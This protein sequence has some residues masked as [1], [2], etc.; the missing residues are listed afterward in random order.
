MPLIGSYSI[1]PTFTE[2]Y[3]S[4]DDLLTQLPDN[5]SNSIVAQD[6]RDAVY[7][8]WKNIEDVSIIASASAT[9]SVQYIRTTPSTAPT[10]GGV[11]TGSTFSG[12]I[13]ETLDRIFYPYIAPASSFTSLSNREFGSPTSV[14]LNWS[15]TKNSNTITT[16]IVD[17]TP[18]LPTG[19]SQAGIKAS[20]GT[21]SS[22]PASSYPNT[23]TMSVSDGTSTILSSV[24]LTWYNRIYWGKVDLSSI[25]SPNLTTNPG[26]AAT[27]VPLV[28]DSTVRNLTGANANGQAFGSELSATKTRVYN[29]IDGGG[30]YLVFAWPSNVAG[31]YTP[32][33]TVN[34]LPSTAF[35]RIRTNSPFNN[36][37]LFSGTNYEVWVSNTAQNAQI[38]LFQI[39]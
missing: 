24:N 25:G 5:T 14:T 29:G 12:T 34:G 21:H 19:N 23:F 36:Q 32:T 10:V 28:N 16:I 1:I 9:A 17:G 37:Y 2:R 15:V 6:V 11:L 3:S 4:V 33:F 22:T 39:S 30:Y 26:L 8:L 20:S 35:T 38:S 13:Q 27:V 7:S 18:V 31:A